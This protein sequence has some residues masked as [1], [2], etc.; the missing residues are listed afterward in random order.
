MNFKSTLMFFLEGFVSICGI[1]P[2]KKYKPNTRNL[3]Y[4]T[5]WNKLSGDWDKLRSDWNRL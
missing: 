3:Q 4:R 1:F 5:N 2:I